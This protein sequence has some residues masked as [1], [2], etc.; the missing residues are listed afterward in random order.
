MTLFV[1]SVSNS[2]LRC[3]WLRWC[4]AVVSLLSAGYVTAHNVG[5]VQTT[6]F[7]APATVNLLKQRVVDGSPGFQVGDLVEYIIQFTPVANGAN[8]TYGANGYLTDYI[9]P[10]TEVVQASFVTLSGYDGSGDAIFTD[11][12]PPAAGLKK[13]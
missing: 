1:R 11:I 2:L 12:T 8:S 7:F 6:K 5:Q 4:V 10:G 9:P 3:H 13:S